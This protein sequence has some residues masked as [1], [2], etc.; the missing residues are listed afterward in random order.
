MIYSFAPQTL[1][2]GRFH[3]VFEASHSHILPSNLAVDLVQTFFRNNI[4]YSLEFGQPL[5]VDMGLP[6]KMTGEEVSSFYNQACGH[7]LIDRY[8][9]L[10]V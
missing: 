7:S 2:K 9:Y 6:Y 3:Q 10:I 8:K 1:V 5:V 4:K